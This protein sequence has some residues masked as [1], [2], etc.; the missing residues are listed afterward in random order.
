MQPGQTV[1]VRDVTLRYDGWSE[2]R[3]PNYTAARG[4]LTIVNDQ[5][6]E[7]EQLFP[8]KRNYDAVQNMTMTEAAI[9][10]RITEDIYVS[11][12]FAYP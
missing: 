1:Q 5:G 11:F 10:H 2:Y 8:E 4:V 12:V 9:L 6:K 3:G 7:F